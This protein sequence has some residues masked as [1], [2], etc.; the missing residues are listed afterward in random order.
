M[1]IPLLRD[2][3]IIFGLSIVVL[4]LTTKVRVPT[5]IGY[6][7]TGV[8]IGP[9]SLGLVHDEH[10]VEILAEVGVVLLLFT[11]GIEFSFKE[12][13][14]IK[15]T[16]L[17]GGSLQVVL[18][19]AVVMGCGA[20]AGFDLN[21][22]A[23]FGFLAALSSTAIVLSLL[24][25]RGEI[26]APHGQG[27]LG[28]LIFQDIAIVPMML[29]TPIL[30]GVAADPGEAL[31]MLLV[32]GV[33]IVAVVIVGARTV[34]PFILD[35]VVRTRRQE[36][37]LLLV[38]A[39]GIGV[40][41]GTSAVGLSLG[42][43]AFL[44]GL[45]IS[46]SEYSVDAL[47]GLLPFRDVFGSFFFVSIG[48]LF[49]WSLLLHEP[50]LIVGLVLGV[51]LIKLGVIIAVARILGWQLRTA[52]M[53]GFS[54]S[55]IGEFSFI[56]SKAG[57]SVEILSAEH[58]QI[59]L[60]V[61]ILTMAATPFLIAAAPQA[62]EKHSRIPLMS[63]LQKRFDKVGEAQQSSEAKQELKGH[64]IV[65]GYGI[66]GELVARAA[67]SAH[68]P[69]II[70]EMNPETVKREKE[71]GE[72]I[73]Y[74]DAS[75]SEVLHH[76]HILQARVVVVAISDADATQRAIR[77]VK[78]MNPGVHLIV[79]TRFVAD[80]DKLAAIGASEVIPAEFE[81]AVEIFSRVLAH[82]L[83]PVD[84]IHR[85]ADHIRADRYRRFRR[86][87][88]GMTRTA[89]LQTVLPD[90]EIRVLRI[91]DNSEAAGK[92]LVQLD[93]RGKFNATIL[94]IKRG[95]NVSTTPDPHAK[96][97][98]NDVAVVM[99]SADA[100]ALTADLFAEGGD[101]QPL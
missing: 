24:Q 6:L 77:Q 14:R 2:I 58:Y 31:L 12:L 51:V 35:R 82:Y 75:K 79:R 99:G 10:S 54:L 39:I 26:E 17:L 18:T 62:A 69:Y 74:G 8:L 41:W 70:L 94:A 20:L 22:S 37:F 36:L 71:R 43:G 76:A 80:V 78:T 15:K 85:F 98:G 73:L 100:I 9:Y 47:G 11:I 87:T 29:L 5:I 40:A 89:D 67:K 61:S 45:I 21:S 16:V 52:I 44:A 57:L 53:V 28:I 25:S 4:Y 38:V 65:I 48:M 93:V 63:R 92:S 34:V 30:A 50:L 33:V 84:E 1:E 55:Q 13:A 72:P 56:L 66:N 88:N 46:E 101:G 90:M 27:T 68:I 81:T 91:F 96:L 97:R 64:V 86:P 42:L 49:D 7:M 59:F 83:L 32:K 23:F 19:I 60:A 95:E 3:A